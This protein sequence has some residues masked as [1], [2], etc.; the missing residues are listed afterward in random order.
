MVAR[1]GAGGPLR[2][3]QYTCFA[4]QYQLKVWVGDWGRDYVSHL[5]QGF[6]GQAFIVR[7]SFF[8]GGSQAHEPLGHIPF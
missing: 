6:G 2:F 8:E 3:F 1:R 4:V 7:T 5:R